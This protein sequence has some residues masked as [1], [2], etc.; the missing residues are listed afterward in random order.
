MIS[1]PALRGHLNEMAQVRND[2][3][4]ELLPTII[5]KSV[6]MRG[7]VS[8]FCSL[9]KT[10]KSLQSELSDTLTEIKQLFLDAIAHLDDQ[11]KI[12]Y[13]NFKNESAELEILE[14]C[15][16]LNPCIKDFRKFKQLPYLEFISEGLDLSQILYT[17]S[18][19]KL[20][21][22]AKNIELTTGCE[23]PILE[24]NKMGLGQPLMTVELSKITAWVQALENSSSVQVATMKGKKDNP[25]VKVRYM[26]RFLALLGDVF[27]FDPVSLEVNLMKEM[28]SPLFLDS[29]R[30]CEKER[31]YAKSIFIDN[32]EYIFDDFLEQ[33][34]FRIYTL[35]N[36]PHHNVIAYNNEAIRG[37]QLAKE[38][39]HFGPLMPQE[40]RNFGV[41]SLVEK[42]ENPL[43]AI[44]WKSEG[45]ALH[46]YDLIEA[47]PITGLLRDMCSQP[48]TPFPIAPHLFAYNQNNEMRA[49][50]FMHGKNRK[51]FE[52][53]EIFAWDC[54]K[55]NPSVFTHLMRAGGITALPQ[56]Q[57]YKSL[58]IAALDN[59]EKQSAISKNGYIQITEI[60]AFRDTFYDTIQNAK[61]E[62]ERKIF[63]IY[64]IDTKTQNEQL[65]QVMCACHEQYGGGHLIFTNFVDLCL[66]MLR[67]RMLPKILF[68]KRQALIERIAIGEK[69][70]DQVFF[71][72]GIVNLEQ[73]SEIKFQGFRKYNLTLKNNSNK[74]EL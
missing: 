35:Q 33:D 36:D 65:K 15:M 47:H 48:M 29:D 23:V 38:K 9:F 55:G 56:A 64:Q 34:Y 26:H 3:N 40:K 4:T 30:D 70:G 20:V 67:P 18:L 32:I 10:D 61:Q 24:L 17:F 25:F 52:R 12:F 59:K 11:L 43:N 5:G 63:G 49:L 14:F 42:C 62:L 41:Y 27:Q 2:L 19:A 1:L 69:I 7:G 39:Y 6:V 73:I 22:K 45:E 31:K 50:C 28:Q 74:L 54:S 37:M 53:L 71:N 72:C 51:S 21:Q 46:D 8:S 44:I 66:T 68:P 57:D 13:N 58:L 16:C 60:L